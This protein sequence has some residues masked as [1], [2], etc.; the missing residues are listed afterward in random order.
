[1]ALPLGL[2]DYC[3]YTLYHPFIGDT[4]LFA[5]L[6]AQNPRRE[7]NL[8]LMNFNDETYPALRGAV[9]RLFASKDFVSSGA[10]SLDEAGYTR[11]V[12]SLRTHAFCLAPRGNGID[13]HRIWE[14]LYAGGIPIT[15]KEPALRSFHDLPIFFVDRWED[16]ADPETL[17]RV[18]D[19]FQGREWNLQ[20]LTVSYWYKLILQLL[21]TPAG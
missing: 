5:R 18:R 11:Y 3:G 20:R 8:V 10:Y 14:C 6:I 13:T 15:Q 2:S 12:E 7:Q 1:M 17:K 19:D 16:A 4:G 9:R 21:H